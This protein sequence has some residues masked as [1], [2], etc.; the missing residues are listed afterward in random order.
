[1]TS[2]LLLSAKMK[3]LDCGDSSGVEQCDSYISTMEVLR[4]LVSVDSSLV[5]S[6]DDLL[7]QDTAR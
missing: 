7:Q 2:H 4:H 1:M 3:F 5:P 6:L